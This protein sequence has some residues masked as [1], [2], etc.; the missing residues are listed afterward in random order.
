MGA[1][2]Y[3]LQVQAIVAYH[4]LAELVPGTD[5]SKASIGPQGHSPPKAQASR[6]GAA[7]VGSER[8]LR[9]SA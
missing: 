4:R 9:I 8:L 3:F 2:A 6:E 1:K 5:V 7:R